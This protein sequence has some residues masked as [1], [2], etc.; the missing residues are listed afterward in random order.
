[1]PLNRLRPGNLPPAPEDCLP[2]MSKKV[3]KYDEKFTPAVAQVFRK[4]MLVRDLKLS[5]IH[6]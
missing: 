2:M 6:I 3:L 1:M 4:S 5:L